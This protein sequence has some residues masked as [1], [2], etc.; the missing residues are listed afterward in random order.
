MHCDSAASGRGGLPGALGAGWATGNGSSRAG[1][2][3]HQAAPAS[4]QG[5]APVVL[6]AT[7][8]RELGLRAH[9]A[10]EGAG[11]QVLVAG[12][13]QTA[14]KVA[15]RELVTLLVLDSELAGADSLALCRAMQEFSTAYIIMLGP[16]NEADAIRALNGG[17]DDYLPKPFGV[18]QLLARVDALLRRRHAPNPQAPTVY[19]YG[20]L[21]ID[22][23]AQ[24]VTV[25]GREI[26]LSPTEFRLLAALARHP[27]IVLTQHQLRET[28]WGPAYGPDRNLL[29]VN[30]RRLRR[31]VEPDA[32]R[33]RYLLTE[34][35]VG[36]FVPKP[37]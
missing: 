1:R 26:A 17:A 15:R 37:R 3:L 9:R 7:A 20:E 32:R 31:K 23:A 2:D 24:R 11:H 10:L 28:V 8:D 16:R 34:H 36:Y 19:A 6:V 27:G 29:H 35:G 4:D 5:K 12:D 22:F 25:A 33:P 18:R 30:V 13:G 14:L 21:R